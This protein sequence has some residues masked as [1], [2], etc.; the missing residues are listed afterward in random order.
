MAMKETCS[1]RNLSILVCLMSS[2]ITL[3][4]L[5]MLLCPFFPGNESLVCM[6]SKIKKKRFVLCLMSWLNEQQTPEHYS[7]T[8]IYLSI[9]CLPSSAF[10]CGLPREFLSS[11]QTTLFSKA[12]FLK[13]ENR[14]WKHIYNKSNLLYCTVAYVI[15]ELLI[16]RARRSGYVTWNTCYSIF[17]AFPGYT[18]N[19]TTSE[20]FIS[21]YYG[22]CE[23]AIELQCASEKVKGK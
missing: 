12:A 15:C 18:G 2:H 6:I 10:C 23:R 22:E 21:K 4:T 17:I 3:V 11:T 5:L 20:A 8:A 13:A 16:S 7:V 14:I 19:Q 1:I 9:K